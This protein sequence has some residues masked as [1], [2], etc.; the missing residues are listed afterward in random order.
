MNLPFLLYYL[1]IMGSL[2][3]NTMFNYGNILLEGPCLI[4]KDK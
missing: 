4:L 2:F 1:C 3:I